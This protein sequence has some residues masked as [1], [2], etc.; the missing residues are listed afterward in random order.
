MI[1]AWGPGALG[2]PW[3]IHIALLRLPLRMDD[4]I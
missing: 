1:E 2:Y 3:V 4:N